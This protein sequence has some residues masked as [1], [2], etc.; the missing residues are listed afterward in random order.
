M[1]A[2]DEL[3]K[4]LDERGVHH[5]GNGEAVRWIGKDGCV[6]RAYSRAYSHRADL[7][8]DV[9]ITYV[10]PERAI[11]ATLGSEEVDE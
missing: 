2:I 10:E 1:S 5:V 11:E 9:A 4:L 8:V 7:C 3:C 6:C